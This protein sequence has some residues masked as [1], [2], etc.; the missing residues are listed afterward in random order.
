M[1]WNATVSLQSFLFGIGAICLGSYYGIPFP[2]LLFYSTI[3]FMQLIEYIVWTY[4][5]LN[6]YA[7]IGAVFL[8]FLQPIASI[9]TMKD[10]RI[11]SIVSYIALTLVYY[12]YHGV[13]P[14]EYHM[15]PG[16]N[17]HLVWKWLRNTSVLWIYFLFLLVPV[18]LTTSIDMNLLIMITLV[19]SLY[20]YYKANTWGSMWCW[21][22][23][24]LV[25]I[26]CIRKMT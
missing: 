23:N 21:L 1:C 3:V 6:F 2:L 25:I 22:I 9:L 19:A 17:G 15:Y 7:S 10:Y 12:M 4:P 11:I 16:T 18:F 20:G 13:H 14:D 8:L 26:A 24:L 5:H